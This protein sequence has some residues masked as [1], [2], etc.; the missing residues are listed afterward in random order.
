MDVWLSLIGDEAGDETR[1]LTQWLREG[2]D[3]RPAT[4]RIVDTLS[5]P[6]SMGTGADLI[7]VAFQQHGVLVALAGVLGTWVGTR[8]RNIKLRVRVGEK[9]VELEGSKLNDPDEI[10]AQLLRELDNHE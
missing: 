4:I 7:Q 8:R 1:R 6:G 5:E 10:A 2:S 3:L 9:E